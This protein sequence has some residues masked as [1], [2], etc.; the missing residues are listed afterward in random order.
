[1]PASCRNG[2][3]QKGQFPPFREAVLF[4]T[5]SSQG[6]IVSMHVL[7]KTLAVCLGAA[8]LPIAMSAQTMASA[9]TTPINS[10][11]TAPISRYD[12]GINVFSYDNQLNAPSTLPAL[13]QLG[14]GMQQFPNANE[15]SW[16]SNSFRSGGKAPV[17]LQDWG[18]ILQS[19]ANQGLFIFNYDE[20]PT[21]TGGGTPGDAAQLTQYIVTHHLPISAIV[22]GSEEYGAW[23]H[24][25]NLNPSFSPQYYAHQS[26]L[27]AQ[28]IHRIDPAMKV[29]VSFTLG[30]GPNSLQWDQ[31]VLREDG[32]YINF[33]SIHDYPNQHTLSNQ[34]LLAS[35][36]NEIAQAMQF[37]QTEITANVSPHYAANIQ[38]WVTEFNPYGQP[39]P[40]STQP[41]Y[42]AA[43]VESAMLWRALGASKLFIWS[44]DGQAHVAS[45]SWPV[46]TNSSK[47]YGLFALAG[48]GQSPELAMNA[49]YPSAVALSQFMQAI[50]P[51]SHLS[52]WATSQMIVGQVTSA[53]GSHIFAINTSTKAETL[54][55][56]H[57]SGQIL[58]ASMQMYH[59]QSVAGSDLQI[60]MDMKGSSST[61]QANVPQIQ[62]PLKGFAGETLTLS[63]TG[64]GHEGAH[65]H[66]IIS[67]NG[68]NYGGPG[69]AYRVSIKS[70]TPH[71]IQFVIPGGSSGPALSPGTAQILVETA[72][73]V[74]SS[75]IPVTIVSTAHLTASITPSAHVYPGQIVTISGSHFGSQEGA[76]YVLISKNG[77]NYG[78]PSDVY[79]VHIVHWT[80]T[81]VQVQIP[82]GTSG[83]ALTPGPASLQIVTATQQSTA[84]LSL[85]I[86]S[87]PH[88]PAAIQTALPVTPGQVVTLS[89]S[90]F[91]SQQRKGYVE[92]SQGTVNY[93]APGDYYPIKILHWSNSQV[94]FMIPTNKE[95]ID[96]RFEPNLN[97]GK[98]TVTITNGSGLKSLPLSITIAGTP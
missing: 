75:T 20:N 80:N 86:T 66:V 87:P 5:F 45:S 53:Q 29:G 73:R 96:N 83:P 14:L 51:A 16:T 84:P 15:W 38:T 93:G 94:S 88:L 18:N 13:R 77:V 43:M 34:A 10:P 39:G 33:V 70:W 72:H 49:F 56:S 11:L 57:G 3:G 22:I 30:Q 7:T 17:S 9:S 2:M 69:D 28:A 81:Q 31:T 58:P 55:L 47:P 52:V 25:A 21:F 92:V 64:F 40:Q 89:G 76:G 24:Y 62:K 19:T 91:G 48:D 8:L 37:V 67:Q 32:P 50:G 74:V 46:A 26:A 95:A 41:V 35:L 27:I 23:D 78:S 6:G 90:G 65:S 36:P 54:P 98:A 97:S 71:Q 44:Y 63:G 82:D 79:K 1:M 42:G 61:Y 85:S 12:Y 60:T 4:S 68:T 59:N